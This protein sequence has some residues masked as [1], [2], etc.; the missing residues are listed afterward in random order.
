M[1]KRRLVRTGL[2]ILALLA[3]CLWSSAQQP[4]TLE[5]VMSVDLVEMAQ[6]DLKD[7]AIAT[8]KETVS[9]SPTVGV[10]EPLRRSCER[11]GMKRWT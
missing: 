10:G 3:S 1:L 8:L 6:N 9:V 11:H 2:V 4:F 7:L 5:Q